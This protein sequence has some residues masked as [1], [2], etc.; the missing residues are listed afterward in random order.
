MTM[1][2][3][4]SCTAEILEHERSNNSFTREECLQHIDEHVSQATTAIS[5]FL[6][7]D[8]SENNN[9]VD[10]DYSKCAENL[11]EELD[12]LQQKMKDNW[13]RA[14]SFKDDNDNKGLKGK[15]HT[16]VEHN[17]ISVGKK[18]SSYSIR[19]VYMELV[20]EAF[21]DEI[22]A[23]RNGQIYEP[24]TRNVKKKLKSNKSN[25]EKDQ[26]SSSST[27]A[28]GFLI[29]E[30]N[31]INIQ[32]DSKQNE[33]IEEIDVDVLV[34]FLE[35]GIDILSKEEQDML[36]TQYNEK[37]KN[38]SSKNEQCTSSSKILTPHERR[39]KVIF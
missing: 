24:E 15:T 28:G 23:L 13:S 10:M 5:N 6:T 19:Q 22:D 14:L 9:R 27:V 20:T 26:S 37:E 17:N 32:A 12:E 34:D 38:L 25:D 31:Q 2:E 39:R 35:S 8:I 7:E 3:T 29:Q 11:F 1:E 30:N 16:T 21:G 33:T 18:D 36:L 4:N